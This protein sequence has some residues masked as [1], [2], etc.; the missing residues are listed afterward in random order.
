MKT[1]FLK[2]CDQSKGYKTVCSIPGVCRGIF[3]CSNGYNNSPITYCV[4]GNS[5]YMIQMP[6]KTP[7]KIAD[8]APGSTPVHFAETAAGTFDRRSLTVKDMPSHLVIVDGEFCYAV[9]TQLRPSNQ[10]ED[11]SVIQLPYTDYEKGITIK[12]SHVAYLYGYIVVNDKN[13]DNFY[14]TYQF[15]FQRT[16]NNN[17]VDKNIFQGW[18]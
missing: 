8:L 14:V 5:L 11:F 10:R 6:S 7:Y 12:P 15:P 3:T 9:N 2:F 17:E 1:M 16:N 13:S 18:F 4:F